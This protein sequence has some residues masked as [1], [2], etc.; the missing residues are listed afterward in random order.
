MIVRDC[1][2][3][4][5]YHYRDFTPSA[6]PGNRA[7]HFWLKGNSTACAAALYDYLGDGFTLLVICSSLKATT[8][9]PLRCA[10]ALTHATCYLRSSSSTTANFANRTTRYAVIRPDQHVAWR[11]EMLPTDITGLLTTVTGQHS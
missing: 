6:R 3:A 1:T 4:P 5:P 2:G 8:R 7:P 9:T 11:G 10:R